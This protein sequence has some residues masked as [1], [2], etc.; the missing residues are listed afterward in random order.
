[1]AMVVHVGYWGGVCI[2]GGA[3]GTL[4]GMGVS[5]AIRASLREDE[6]IDWGWRIPFLLTPVIGFAGYVIRRN[7]QE[8]EEFEAEAEK[9]AS[10]GVDTMKA[11]IYRELVKKHWLEMLLG[12]F[13]VVGWCPT[14]YLV[15]TWYKRISFTSVIH[16]IMCIYI[17]VIRTPVYLET[18]VDIKTYNA[19]LLNFLFLL[20]FVFLLPLFG[21]MA[22]VIVARNDSNKR[23]YRLY[24]ASSTFIFLVL[25][26][27]A[28]FL[29]KNDVLGD[30]V[31]GYLFLSV[32]LAMV[33]STTRK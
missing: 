6:L 27:P 21:Y 12:L 9:S 16:I 11:Q 7:I 19:W 4:I 22:D 1:M 10:M 33:G 23:F 5:A 24:L 26:I 18:I 3:L 25:S 2:V 29:L 28:Y 20:L 13:S 30:A 8:T 14:F 15:F 17:L 31:L 32:P